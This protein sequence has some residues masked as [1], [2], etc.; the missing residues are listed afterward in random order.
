MK[1]LYLS[2]EDSGMIVKQFID[3]KKNVERHD[4]LHPKETWL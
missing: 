3:K 1:L 2:Q 4:C